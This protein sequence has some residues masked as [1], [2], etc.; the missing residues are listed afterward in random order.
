MTHRQR[1]MLRPFKV[2]D[3]CGRLTIYGRKASLKHPFGSVGKAGF[4]RRVM[5]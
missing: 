2:R 4:L 1:K 5:K 3:Y